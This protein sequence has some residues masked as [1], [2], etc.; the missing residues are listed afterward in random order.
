MQKTSGGIPARGWRPSGQLDALLRRG[1]GLGLLLGL[2]SCGSDGVSPDPT[3][4][5][6]PVPLIALSPT[7]VTF[8]GIQG[9]GDPA[10]VSVAIANPVA[11]STLVGL[12]VSNISYTGAGT[13]WL[14]A[15]LASTQ[16][17]TTLTLRPGLG[18]LGAGSYSA[19]VTLS[20]SQSGVAPVTLGVSLQLSPQ[21]VG[22]GLVSGPPAMVSG[23]VAADPWVVELRDAQ[24]NRV[25]GA[26]GAVTVALASGSGTLVGTT[27]VSA[28]A[29]VA[30]FTNLRIDGA[31][32]HTLAFTSA[33]LTGVTSSALTVTQ[34]AAALAIQTQPAG[35]VTGAP[36][37]TQPVVRV[38]DE[39]GLLVTTG[40]GATLAVTASVASGGGTL[41]GATT[42]SAVGGVATFT[43]L[44]I[45]GTGAHTLRFATATPALEVVSGSFSVAS[46]P[47]TQLAITTQPAGAVSGRVL[48]TQP[49]VELRDAQ[50]NRVTGATGAVT[51]ALASGSG[52]LVGTTT[53]SAVAGVATFT[54]LRIDGAGAHTLAFT[55]AGLTGVTSTAITVA[56][57]A[58]ALSIQTQPAGAVTGVALTTQPVVR[59]LDEAGLL[60]TTGTGA[61]LA[62]TASV[63]SGGGTL[64][65]T[66]TVSAVGGVATFTSLTITGT[67]AHTLRFATATPALEVISQS[68]T[69]SAPAVPSSLTV[70]LPNASV[71][72]N[73]TQTATAEV[74]DQDG[75]LMTG[76]TVVWSVSNP[77]VARIAQT[78]QLQ[79]LGAGSTSVTATLGALSDSKTLNV[80]AQAS[81]FSITL[82]NLTPL[83][84]A[85]QSAFD[86][87][88]QRWEGIVVGNLP[89]VSVS[90][91]DVNSCTGEKLAT[92][93][94]TIDDLLIFVSVDS[95]DGP[96]DG[97]SNILGRAGPCYTRGGGGLP[98]IGSM[99]FDE[100]DLQQLANAGLLTDVILHEM[101]HVLGIGTLWNSRGFLDNPAEVGE[102]P[103]C[104]SQDPTFNGVNGRW[105]SPLLIPSYGGGQ[106]PVEN[107]GGTGTRNG[108]WRESLFNRELM[109]GFLSTSGNPL[110]PLT[111][112]SLIDLGYV[113]NAAQADSQPWT[114]LGLQ[115]GELRIRLDELPMPAPRS[116]D[117]QGRV[118]GGG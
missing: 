41:S 23:R 112:V 22:L 66:A 65:G 27:T 64:S 42:V 6:P 69:V 99:V 60:V 111:I 86:A 32:A 10:P 33:G 36:L 17:P 67:G 45:T 21:P 49:V 107:C 12:A 4:P 8:Q 34:T 61:T 54:N 80:S 110:S 9:G 78:G 25:T 39:A 52:T 70:V 114:A 77:L 108:H 63:A 87:A 62:V 7:A 116:L 109:T 35:A 97:T 118:I 20:S 106:V 18:A 82:E 94:G 57:M 19:T 102:S 46:A 3:P 55:S 38:L 43:S 28:V 11:G 71:S 73:P 44:A 26:T 47:P 72:G 16:A 51:V 93:S 31:G 40:A 15:E 79:A 103:A 100:Y 50:G 117:E 59:V 115:P 75:N 30:T 98:V 24:G 14:T 113:V 53:V 58:A 29:G 76:Q 84:P 48:T 37:T 5:P 74:R 92:W 1:L 13:G 2:S 88:K 81:G 104:L 68:L 101:G 90:G 56:Q 91:L 105:I 83:A 85:I 96:G 89:A 95:I